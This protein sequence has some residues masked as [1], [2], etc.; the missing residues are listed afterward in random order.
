MSLKNN[1][2][3][4][5][6]IP[7]R[8]VIFVSFVVMIAAGPAWVQKNVLAKNFSRNKCLIFFHNIS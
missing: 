3:V 1:R 6:N 7:V 4:L 8:S 5:K 2:K